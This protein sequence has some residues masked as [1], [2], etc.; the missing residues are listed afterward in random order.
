MHVQQKWLLF[1]T[2]EWTNDIYTSIYNCDVPTNELDYG[3][4]LGTFTAL[5]KYFVRTI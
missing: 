3:A 1:V 2:R 4:P 5:Y